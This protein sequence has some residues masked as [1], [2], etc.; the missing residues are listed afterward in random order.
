MTEIHPWTTLHPF[1]FF[2]VIRKSYL[3]LNMGI[4]LHADPIPR[5]PLGYPRRDF[6]EFSDANPRTG[7]SVKQI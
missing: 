3:A 6:A 1:F 2:F 7:F 4:S 5:E